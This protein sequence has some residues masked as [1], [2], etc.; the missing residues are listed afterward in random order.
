MAYRKRIAKRSS[1]RLFKKNAT[2][3][4][5]KNRASGTRVMRGGYRA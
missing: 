2:R 3:V 5:K 4:H 1:K